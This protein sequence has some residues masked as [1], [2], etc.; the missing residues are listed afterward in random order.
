MNAHE[1][2]EPILDSPF[3]EPEAHCG[4]WGHALVSDV[5]QLREAVDQ[6][7]GS[8]EVGVSMEGA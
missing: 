3:E 4:G 1:V 5:G 8:G 7:A 6:A 2:P